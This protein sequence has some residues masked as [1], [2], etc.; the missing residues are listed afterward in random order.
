MSGK[1]KNWRTHS[2]VSAGA[3]TGAVFTV[4]DVDRLGERRRLTTEP[5]GGGCHKHS[6]THMSPGVAVEG[7]IASEK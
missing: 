7:R 5:R 3:K 6:Q 4:I 2:R 1:Q